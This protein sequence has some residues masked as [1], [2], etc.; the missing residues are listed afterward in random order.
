MKNQ[1]ISTK[2]I[3]EFY[4]ICHVGR[5]NA[6]ALILDKVAPFNVELIP[7]NYITKLLFP[8]KIGRS[9]SNSVYVIIILFKNLSLYNHFI[10]GYII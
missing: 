3:N 2:N 7:N 1:R 9:I 4:K 5:M 6:V 10:K 8:E